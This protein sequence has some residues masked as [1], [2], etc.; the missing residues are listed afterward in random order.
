VL[1]LLSLFLPVSSPAAVNGNG[2]LTEKE[3]IDLAL[4]QHPAVKESQERMAAAKAQIGISR[5]GYLPQANFT[6]N[7]Y[8]GNAFSFS[9][10]GISTPATTGRAPG[11]TSQLLTASDFY[12]YR[13]NFNQLIYDFGKTMGAIAVARA[14]YQQAG[15]DY[16][17]VR[18]GVVLDARTAYF[19]LL[20]AQR[21]VK[22]EEE[23]VRQNQEL[24]RQAQ[25][26]YGV[27]ARARIDVTKA[28]ANLYDAETQLIRARNL[29]DLARV[30]LMTAL[31]LKN[32]PYQT[33]EDA[34]EAP[35]RPL[36][37]A[38]LKE[39]A[40]K[41]RPEVMRNRH[42]QEGDQA[43]LK[44]ARAGYFP[45]LSSNA[46]Y[47]WQGDG[48][49]LASNWWLGVAVNV[50]LFEGLKTK[51]SVD[52]AKAQLRATLANAEVLSQNVNK[53]VEQ[54]YLDVQT[55][56]EVIRSAAKAREAAQENLRLAQGRY[57]AGV[58]SIIEVT[59]AQVQFARSD[60]RYVQALYDYRIADAKLDKAVGRVY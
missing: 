2:R 32:W 16:A 21:A 11:S 52:Q 10:G 60:L 39:Q 5:S 37:L 4:K 26:F 24:L 27:G 29:V 42:Q 18:Q 41:Q 23:N 51:Y 8:Y 30:S 9:S 50:P 19:G 25:G 20:A 1:C 55:A 13:F 3:A 44:V 59:D 43:N 34:L 28:E 49:P 46:S 53:E 22:V 14:G 36:V 40:L 33:L 47:G 15:D 17:G 31:G 38:E 54:N 6:G 12:I 45:T 57:K 7:Y 48:Y 35:P 56:R 58:G